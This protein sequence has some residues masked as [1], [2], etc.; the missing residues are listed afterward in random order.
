MRRILNYIMI[1]VSMLGFVGCD[2]GGKRGVDRLW[3]SEYKA[4]SPI[5][6]IS[7]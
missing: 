3:S 2:K 6:G 1:A 7:G 5:K 4:I